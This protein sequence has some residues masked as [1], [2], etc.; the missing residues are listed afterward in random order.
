MIWSY[1]NNIKY[2][3][4]QTN[5]MRIQ[6]LAHLFIIISLSVLLLILAQN[7]LIPIVLAV[8]IW[9]IIREIKQFFKKIGFVKRKVPSWLLNILATIGLFATIG[10]VV[11]VVSSNINVLLQKAPLY[12]TNLNKMLALVDTT[13][14]VDL[15]AQLQKYIGDVNVSKMISML[16][17]F[18]SSLFGNIFIILIYILFLLIEES[19]FPRK[20]RAFYKDNE[21][22]NKS[23]EILHKIDKSIGQYLFL[24]TLVSIITAALSFGVLMIIGVNGAFFWAFLIFLL[25]YIPNIGSLIASVFPAIFAL[26][27]FGELGP[28]IWVFVIIVAIQIVV[29]NLLEPKI[30]GNSLNLSPLVVLISLSVWGAIW[31]IVG[32]ALSVPITVIMLILLSGFPT[33]RP[34]AVLLSEKGRLNE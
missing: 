33:T 30:M 13:F 15:N 12:E 9:F 20:M 3:Y 1:S 14:G 5:H 26:L 27:Q 32:M 6:K 18:I 25:N 19:G 17:N 10:L 8:F 16:V 31:G 2:F 29:G 4:C 7:L 24:K 23:N 22:F 11:T 34:I 21:Q 28:A